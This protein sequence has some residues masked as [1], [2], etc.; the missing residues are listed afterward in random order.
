MPLPKVKFNTYLRATLQLGAM[1]RLV[2]VACAA[3]WDHGGG[4]WSTVL[5]L[6]R[7]M[8]GSV[9][10]QQPES[11]WCLACVTPK[12]RQMSVVCLKSCIRPWV[13]LLLGTILMPIAHVTPAAMLVSLACTAATEN[14][15]VHGLCC[16][17]G[18]GWCPWSILPPET[19]LWS[20]ECAETR[21]HMEVHGLSSC[22]L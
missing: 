4:H 19:K 15:G 7:A 10:L 20:M 12:A 22:W 16:S 13:M 6:Q 18:L 5:L 8:A 1:L 2:A 21:N 14:Y 9:V 11:C 3:I 17:R